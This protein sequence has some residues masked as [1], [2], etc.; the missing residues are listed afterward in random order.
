MGATNYSPYTQNQIQLAKVFKALGHPGRIAIMELLSQQKALNLTDINLHL[1]MTQS[2][3]SRHCRELA[4]VG[5][6]NQFTVGNSTYYAVNPPVLEKII[7]Y[8]EKMTLSSIRLE[9]DLRFLNLYSENSFFSK[10]NNYLV[11]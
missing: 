5:L 1:K 4:I 3:L 10:M 11:T 7:D 8:V 9:I 6:L 2:N